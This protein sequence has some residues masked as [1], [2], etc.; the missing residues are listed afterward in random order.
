MPGAVLAPCGR[1]DIRNSRVL[2]GSARSSSLESK[3]V[4][5]PAFAQYSFSENI[6]KYFGHVCG[7]VFRQRL[8]LPSVLPVIESLNTAL[9]NGNSNSGYQ[10]PMCWRWVLP[11]LAKR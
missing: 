3:C 10:R 2:E 6:S 11:V 7:E 9:L 1:L 5:D 8:N 4:F